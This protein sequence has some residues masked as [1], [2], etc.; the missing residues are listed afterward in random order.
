MWWLLAR[1]VLRFRGQILRDSKWD[2]VVDLFFY[3]DPEE[4]EKDEQAAKEIAAPPPKQIEPPTEYIAIP[5]SD[6]LLDSAA[7]GATENWNDEAAPALPATGAPGA[8]PAAAASTFDTDWTTPV[9]SS[10]ARDITSESPGGQRSLGE[11]E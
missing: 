5:V 3:R 10:R 8:A 2:V 1:E 7:A 11:S 6:P 9:V 4:A